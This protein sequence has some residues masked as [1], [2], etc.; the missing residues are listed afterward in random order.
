MLK[1]CGLLFVCWAT[2]VFAGI[3]Q[4]LPSH[5]AMGDCRSN[6]DC[7]PDLCCLLGKIFK[8]NYRIKLK[9]YILNWTGMM[10]YSTPWC[11]PLLH[12]GEDC[13]PT[14][15]N[16][17]SIINRTLA[18]PGGLEIF[19]KDAYQVLNWNSFRCQSNK[20]KISLFLSQFFNPRFCVPVTPIKD[21]NAVTEAERASP[22]KS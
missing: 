8:K 22:A 11:A 20:N 12:F 18:Y 9:I 10:R 1:E 3:L 7:G 5:S 2:V 15:S 4:P 17:P 14:S 13:R 6:E 19:L 16:E 21:S